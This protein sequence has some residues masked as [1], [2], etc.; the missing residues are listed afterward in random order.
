M[1][2]PAIPTDN[3]YKFV[4]LAGVAL[5]LISL[6]YPEQALRDLGAKKIDSETQLRV[7]LAQADRLESELDLLET[8][9]DVEDK[10]LDRIKEQNDEIRINALK[11]SGEN[12]KIALY[13]THHESVA[14]Y[15]KYL[16][17]LGSAMSFLGFFLWYRRVQRPADLAVAEQAKSGRT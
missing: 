14:T 5:V 2:I 6:I 7:L 9:K 1:Y 15:A 13:A 3:L 4:A 8:S 11:A 16:L 12:Q 17:I 10:R